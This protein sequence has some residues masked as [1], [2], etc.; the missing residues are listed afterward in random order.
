[1]IKITLKISAILLFLTIGVGFAILFANSANSNEL[2]QMGFSFIS[3]AIA[4][5][6]ATYIIKTLK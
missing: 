6:I 3:S 2:L 5:L 1:M 4:I